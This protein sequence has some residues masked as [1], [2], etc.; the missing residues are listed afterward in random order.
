MQR[1]TLSLAWPLLRRKAFWGWRPSAAMSSL[2]IQQ[3][4]YSWLKELGL[5][6]DNPGVFNGSWGGS[7]EVSGA[8]CTR[9]NMSS[10]LVQL[11]LERPPDQLI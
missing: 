4:K 1:V 2:L 10:G 5:K 9:C 7:G 6:E 11:L 3:P 8:G